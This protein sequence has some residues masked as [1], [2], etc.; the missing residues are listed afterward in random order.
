MLSKKQINCLGM[1]VSADMTQRQIAEELKVTEQTI[2]AWKKN[3]EFIEGYNNLMRSTV[4]SVSAKALKTMVKL[5]DADSEQ[6]RLNAAKDILDRAGFKP[7]DKV[8]ISGNVNNPLAGLS[9]EDL[10]KLVAYD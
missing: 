3:P 1:L 6:V 10:K 2:C 5:L 8:E 7:E 9:T 4:R